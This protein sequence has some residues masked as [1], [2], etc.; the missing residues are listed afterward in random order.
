MLPLWLD[1][2]DMEVLYSTCFERV[3]LTKLT[4]LICAVLLAVLAQAPGVAGFDESA[5]GDGDADRAGAISAIVISEIHYEPRDKRAHVE[6]VEL[7]NASNQR[8]DL[9]GWAFTD[10]ISYEF[11]AGTTLEPRRFL[12]VA[13]DPARLQQHYG[14]AAV[15][16]FSGRL[17]NE[18]DLL[19]L[20]D[21]QANIVDS[22]EYGIGFPW[23]IGGGD[24]DFSIGLVAVG[25]DNA[26]AGAW[27]AGRATPGSPNM[28]VTDN[29]P[30]FVESVEHLPARPTAF[31]T[32]QV[33][34]KVT[35]ADGVAEVWLWLQDVAPGNYIRLTDPAY[36][37]NWSAV[38][39]QLVGPDLFAAEVPAYM[40]GHR[41]LIRYRIEASDRVGRRLTVPYWEDPQP[42]FALYIYNGAPGWAGMIRPGAIGAEGPMGSGVR[43]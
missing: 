9:S 2:A 5:D 17:A 11:P 37:A 40:R 1:Y 3:R 8:V 33:Q 15:G 30:P 43:A 34:A 20:R 38:P 36:A 14:A 35:D 26:I 39:M 12:L 32:V 18:G 28:F 27:R 13:A 42:N 21:A 41:H 31:D 10:G 19:V 16:P 6:F 7:F 24:D 22:V 25:L 29:P 4:C 23:P